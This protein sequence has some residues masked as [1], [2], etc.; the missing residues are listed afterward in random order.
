MMNR[1]QID[2][3]A[4][5]AISTTP[6]SR[7]LFIPLMVFTGAAMAFAHGSN[8]VANGIGPMAVRSC[9]SSRRK[10]VS[11]KSAVTP[12]MLFIGG[13]GIVVG[14]ATY[15]YKV[16]AT[17]GHKITELT[18]TRGYSATVRRVD[19][20]RSR[21]PAWDCRCRRRTSRSAP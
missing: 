15:G 3:P 12:F 1:I 16:M 14:L 10:S 13:I 17:I 5:T 11:S 9:R 21:P 4:T 6:A 7:R 18:P 2:E 20:D 8:D 19:R